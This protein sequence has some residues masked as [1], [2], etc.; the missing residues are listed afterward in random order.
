[1][2]TNTKMIINYICDYL[3]REHIN[4]H[5]I[6]HILKTAFYSKEEI[7]RIRDIY[8]NYREDD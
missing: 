8:A 1:M 7:E 2:A 5:I 6:E 3:S 4:W